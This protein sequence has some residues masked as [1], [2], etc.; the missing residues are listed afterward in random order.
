MSLE[1]P[2][3]KMAKD[4]VGFAVSLIRSEGWGH[5]RVDLERILDLSPEGSLV[6]EDEDGP[7]GFI[8]SVRYGHTAMIGHLLVS[9]GSRGRN[10]GRSLV[11]TLLDDI[12]SMGIESCMLYATADGGRL[13]RQ[14][15]FKDSVH[16]LVAVGLF[17]KDSERK[18]LE[19]HCSPLG[20]DDLAELVLLD[21]A[22]F[23]DDRT[24]ITKRLFREF[25]EH[26]FKLERSG[27]IA[28]Y[29]LGRRTPIGF[30]IGPWYCLTDSGEDAAVLL[31]AALRS[32]PC[33]GR[34]DI[35]PFASNTHVPRIIA[36]FRKYRKAERVKLM[37]R[38][39]Q[40]Y[41]SDSDKVFGVTGFE[42]G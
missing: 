14:F 22:L 25:P 3:R 24:V 37:I 40:R 35:S 26:A 27:D 30:D 41:T 31:D 17:L 4:D 10:I 6:W 9:S 11:D 28:G 38:G 39:E 29:I 42:L 12:D 7:C 13:Y 18:A 1:M 34:V 8:T 19:S 15:G 23:G 5:T 21:A 33:G 2:A 20:D 36:R 32:L 16:E